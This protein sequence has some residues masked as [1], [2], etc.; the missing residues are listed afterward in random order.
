MG[1]MGTSRNWEIQQLR[2]FGDIHQQ[3]MARRVDGKEISHQECGI[4]MRKGQAGWKKGQLW[5]TKR[6]DA[7]TGPP[8]LQVRFLFI[9]L[10]TLKILEV[11]W[12]LLFPRACNDV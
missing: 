8:R 9:S 5:S 10:Y 11:H 3:D 7:G 6:V 2:Y 4:W 1:I 12:R